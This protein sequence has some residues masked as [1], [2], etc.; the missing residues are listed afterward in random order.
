MKTITSLCLRCTDRPTTGQP[1]GPP[2]DRCTICNRWTTRRLVRW[3]G[4]PGESS[5]PT[6]GQTKKQTRAGRKAGT[7]GQGAM[8]NFCYR[9][10]HL[11]R[12]TASITTSE[13]DA[14]RPLAILR[15]SPVAPT[16]IEGTTT[17]TTGGWVGLGSVTKYTSSVGTCTPSGVPPHTHILHHTQTLAWAAIPSYV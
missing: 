3:R 7:R 1:M 9:K 5:Q 16:A 4:S 2:A 8:K 12:T 10:S 13:G 15:R 11:L 6:W 17:E 14:A